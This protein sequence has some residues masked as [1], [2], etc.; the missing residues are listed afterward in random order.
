MRTLTD[1]RCTIQCN[2][3]LELTK[4]HVDRPPTSS[5]LG[6]QNHHQMYDQIYLAPRY[7]RPGYST[8]DGADELIVEYRQLEQ[9]NR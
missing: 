6:E 3:V 5:A 9:M 8:F 7:V 2:D 4:R 1:P